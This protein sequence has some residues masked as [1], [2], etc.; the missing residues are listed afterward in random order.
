MEKIEEKIFKI[1]LSYS[2]E[3]KDLEQTHRALC[4]LVSD[5]VWDQSNWLM[6]NTSVE[7]EKIVDFK[8]SFTS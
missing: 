3:S 7:V 4:D 6:A 8:Q 2:A 5:L 1:L